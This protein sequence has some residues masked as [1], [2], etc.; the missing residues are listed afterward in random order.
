MAQDSDL[1]SKLS[2]KVGETDPPLTSPYG[3]WKGVAR[4]EISTFA[5]S[6]SERR[7][8]E[9]IVD[10]YYMISHD[11]VLTP[12]FKGVWYPDHRITAGDPKFFVRRYEINVA[13]VGPDQLPA[14][15]KI[16]R[17]LV[18]T[19]PDKFV[20][21]QSQPPT[22]QGATQ[23]TT[24]IS[25]SFSVNAG[26]FGSVVQG[27]ASEGVTLSNSKSFSIPDMSIVNQS[28]G[29]RSLCKFNIANE[30]AIGMSAFQ[31]TVQHVFRKVDSLKF[32]QSA[33]SADPTKFATAP[34]VAFRV[35]VLAMLSA[36]YHEDNEA[37]PLLDLQPAI[38][39][40]Y[41]YARLPPLPD[42]NK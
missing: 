20:V 5:V 27:G 37:D 9:N 36:V 1:W 13:P 40:Q 18:D 31:P 24:S 8:Q 35:N 7:M 3:A 14:S 38:V 10:D 32:P 16:D 22:T 34:V 28:A 29:N 39:D 15:E 11:F 21:M 6:A 4:F 42:D 26:F 25:Q 30:A 23:V 17:K 33:R 12:N 41:V 19:D 2:D